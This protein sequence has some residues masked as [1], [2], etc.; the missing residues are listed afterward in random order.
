MHPALMHATGFEQPVS[1]VVRVAHLGLG[2][3]DL[4]SAT[5]PGSEVA[6]TALTDG[7]TDVT[8]AP[9]AKTYGLDDTARFISDGKLDP[10]MFAQDAVSSRS[11]RP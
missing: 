7:S 4:L 10:V 2:G 11:T 3:Y 5:T 8:I 6:N 9:R 1:N